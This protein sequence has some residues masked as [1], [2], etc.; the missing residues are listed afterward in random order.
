MAQSRKFILNNVSTFAS[1]HR[2]H[3]IEY[4]WEKLSKFKFNSENLEMIVKIMIVIF[5]GRYRQCN[6]YFSLIQRIDS[7]DTN[8][9]NWKEFFQFTKDRE[10]RKKFCIKRLCQVL[11]IFNAMASWAPSTEQKTA[12]AKE[13]SYNT[14]ETTLKKTQHPQF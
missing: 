1:R 8:C 4:H 13:I 2:R 5:M 6:L 3:L 14:K 12:K 9:T 10:M 11:H 7:P